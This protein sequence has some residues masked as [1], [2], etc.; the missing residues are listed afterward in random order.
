[1]R[2]ADREIKDFNEIVDILDRCNTIRLGMNGEEYPYVV[3]LSFGFE[4]ADEKITIYIHGAKEGLKHDLIA[5]DN[6]V[7]VE[8]SIFHRFIKVPRFNN[9]TTEYESF[10]GFGEANI[11]YDDEAIKG[12]DLI[13]EHA[14]YKGFR[15]SVKKALDFA[16]VYKIRLERFTGKRRFVEQYDGSSV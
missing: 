13:C 14:G 6:Y 8:A 2:R 9:L 15:Y 10:I 3:P 5:K 16:R 7:C 12:L 11:A 4:A 1:M